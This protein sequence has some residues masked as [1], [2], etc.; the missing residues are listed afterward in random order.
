MKYRES[1]AFLNPVT[2]NSVTLFIFHVSLW[3]RK[4]AVF[5]IGNESSLTKTKHNST[6]VKGNDFLNASMVMT[7]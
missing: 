7:R 5:K 3:P 2:K 1:C 4:E 6:E